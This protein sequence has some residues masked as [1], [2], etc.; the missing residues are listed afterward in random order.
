MTVTIRL[1]N[2]SVELPAEVHERIKATGR[3]LGLHRVNT[4]GGHYYQ[5]VVK[6]MTES[7]DYK[8]QYLHAYML[9]YNHHTQRLKFKDGNR[10]NC[11]WDNIVVEAR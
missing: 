8:K 5:P 2:A 7:G 1:A 6:W 11:S 3:A 4:L 9:D 10:L